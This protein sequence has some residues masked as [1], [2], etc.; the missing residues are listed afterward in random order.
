V[1]SREPL[2]V[3][4]E[5]TLPD[6]LREY[7]SAFL[8]AFKSSTT[9][10]R[11]K[12]LQ[13]MM[14]ALV[15]SVSA[16]MKG[17]SRKE[18]VVYYKDIIEKAWKQVEEADTPE[19]R[20]ERYSEA[21]DWTMMDKDYDGRTRRMFGG[22]PVYMPYWW[23]RADPTV[24]RTSPAAGRALGG[25]A[26]R[27]SAPTAPSGGRSKTITLPRLPGS[28]AAA[29]VTNTVTAMS[30]G[31]VGNLAAFTGGVTNVTNPAPKPTSSTFRSTGGGGRS[32]GGS[33]CACACACAG[34][35]C[36]CA[37]GGR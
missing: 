36:A 25:T 18:T 14:V 29:S 16:K 2:T 20:A 27:A 7:E 22:G 6:D 37:G 3:K 9:S 21:V 24:A 17:F 34:C 13:D 11:R 5:E 1:T 31:A 23:W 30:A 10:T 26:G 35:A 19:V 28:D 32:G 8:E 33:S 4:V 12:K 15:N